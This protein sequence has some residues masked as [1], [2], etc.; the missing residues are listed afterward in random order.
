MLVLSRK[1]GERIVIDGGI[2]VTVVEIIGNRVK[3]GLE[4]PGHVSIL[5][6]ELMADPEVAEFRKHWNAEATDVGR[7]PALSANEKPAPLA[8]V[9]AT[10]GPV[11]PIQDRIRRSL[12]RVRT[13]AR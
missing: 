6:G 13:A 5:R 3:I 1:P 2:T 11:A 7:P 10:E 8:G 12:R 9:A 4:A